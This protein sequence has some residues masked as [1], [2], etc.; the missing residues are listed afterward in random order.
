MKLRGEDTSS[1][2]SQLAAAVPWSLLTVDIIDGVWGSGWQLV[3]AKGSY[4]IRSVEFVDGKNVPR[5][6]IGLVIDNERIK[7]ISLLERKF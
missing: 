3:A 1:T 6:A 2:Y 7:E 5:T 4:L